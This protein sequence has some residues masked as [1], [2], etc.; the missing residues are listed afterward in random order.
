MNVLEL[1]VHALARGVEVSGA[2]QAALTMNGSRPLTVADY[3][4]TGGITVRIG[5]DYVNAP[6]GEWYCDVP[7][8]VVDVQDDHVVLLWQGQ[9]VDIEVLPLP[10]YLG[11]PDAKGVMTHAD[12]LRLSPV[13]GCR[14][15]CEF[16]DSP[17]TPYRLHSV[18]ALAGA[19]S[20]AQQDK[21]LSPRHGLISGGTPRMGDL[22]E[23]DA[24]VLELVRHSP[25]PMDVMLMP[26]QTTD[27]IDALV[28]AGVDGLS[29]NIELFGE[30]AAK[31]LVPQ[32]AAQGRDG[33]SR[34]WRRAV[35]RLGVGR[36]R[37]LL[38]VGLEPEADTLAGVEFIASHGV[39]PVLSPFRPAARTLHSAQRPPS[40]ELMLRLH[41]AAKEAAEA[42]GVRLGPRCV[43]CQ[44]NVIA[45][46][47]DVA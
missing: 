24:T 40:A 9:R 41:T 43:P 39:D 42:H 10:G 11:R 5:D 14:C 32:K 4:T 36:V 22:A 44:H 30:E 27:F 31:R 12:R 18:D 8:A 26:R 20:V 29:I 1:K 34:A 6:V 21:R 38:V 23:F 17:S 19:L 35:E 25:I 46:A 16:C 7:A 45:V 37:S 28:D 2:A 13:D 3:A 33:Y 15:T 47:A